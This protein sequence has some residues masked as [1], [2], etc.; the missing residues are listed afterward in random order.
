MAQS[1]NINF[2]MSLPYISTDGQV[3]YNGKVTMVNIA[4]NNYPNAMTGKAT[5]AA[6][7]IRA[8]ANK[9]S[10]ANAVL[11][12]TI[13]LN[14]NRIAEDHQMQKFPENNNI[15]DRSVIDT[16]KRENISSLASQDLNL[17]HND[18][19]TTATEAVSTFYMDD[20]TFT[21]SD[22]AT[23]TTMKYNNLG[24]NNA[25]K[26]FQNDVV[27]P[28]PASNSSSISNINSKPEYRG[29]VKTHG[30]LHQLQH[31]QSFM[32]EPPMTRDPTPSTSINNIR[33]AATKTNANANSNAIALNN[34][35][36]ASID[37][38][39]VII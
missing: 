32:N 26:A 18:A 5:A 13:K 16:Y 28:I 39:T 21:T 14:Q 34:I 3:G 17:S 24:M 29:I 37:T 2:K 25:A 27:D 20:G 19:Q 7:K 11:R 8:T 4:S 36:L 12:D 38:F 22:N 10:V 9:E 31:V 15:N 33:N 35:S 6:D 23:N 1:Q 30:S